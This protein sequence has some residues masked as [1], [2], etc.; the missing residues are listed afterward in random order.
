[1][2][3]STQACC[4]ELNITQATCLFNVLTRA[5]GVK[6]SKQTHRSRVLNL[7]ATQLKEFEDARMA[8]IKEHA[9]KD[10]A[11]EPKLK[12][13][14]NAYDLIDQKAFDAAFDALRKE[15]TIILDGRSDELRNKALAAVFEIL[16]GD[17]CPQLA[18]PQ[19]GQPTLESEILVFADVVDA[20]KFE[21]RAK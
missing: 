1:M 20:F 7:L 6:G 16:T 14:G 17:D 21:A 13:G 10:E 4:V 12:T 9:H 2:A 8:L 18:P 19:P 15:Q 11:G 5:G 3:D